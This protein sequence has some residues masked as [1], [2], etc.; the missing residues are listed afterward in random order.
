LNDRKREF[1]A[2]TV[3]SAITENSLAGVTT[4]GIERLASKGAFSTAF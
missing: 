3:I 4:P 1:P 2:L